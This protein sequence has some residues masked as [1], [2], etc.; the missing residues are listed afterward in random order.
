MF[1]FRFGAGVPDEDEVMH[2]FPSKSQGGESKGVLPFGH[3]ILSLSSTTN[4]FSWKVLNVMCPTSSAKGGEP[5]QR[6]EENKQKITWIEQTNRDPLRNDLR[7]CFVS[8]HQFNQ[9]STICLPASED[10][11]HE[12]NNYY[13]AIHWIEYTCSLYLTSYSHTTFNFRWNPIFFRFIFA[14]TT[15]KNKRQ[16]FDY[17]LYAVNSWLLPPTSQTLLHS[18][19]LT[20][21]W[22]LKQ[23]NILSKKEHLQLVLEAERFQPI[24]RMRRFSTSV[25]PFWFMNT[26]APDLPVSKNRSDICC[27]LASTFTV[28][29]LFDCFFSVVFLGLRFLFHF[30]VN[31]KLPLV[32]LNLY[33]LV[34]HTLTRLK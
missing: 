6:R 10:S 5:H 3:S 23:T 24:L 21:T 34:L 9:L 27:W 19:N 13:K 28:C 11:L 29:Y 17:W 7:Q 22:L 4:A 32:S 18:M 20:K 30:F 16:T 31:C 25:V 33:S 15:F 14:P 1:A 2:L 26:F 8:K 12:V